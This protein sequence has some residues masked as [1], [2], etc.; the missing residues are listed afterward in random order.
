QVAAVA[1]CVLAILMEGRGLRPLFD[2]LI[3]LGVYQVQGTMVDNV[4]GVIFVM[5]NA[6]WGALLALV[7]W[8]GTLV[9]PRLRRTLQDP[10]AQVIGFSLIATLATLIQFQKRPYPHYA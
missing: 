3:V 10:A 9:V 6:I 1:A 5:G 7:I 4:V 8:V 2:G